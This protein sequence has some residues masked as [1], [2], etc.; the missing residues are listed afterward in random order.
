MSV[1]DMDFFCSGQQ[2]LFFIQIIQ[3]DYLI[4]TFK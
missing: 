1:N 3:K 4:N 2:H